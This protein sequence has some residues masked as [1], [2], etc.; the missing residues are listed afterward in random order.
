MSVPAATLADNAEKSFA[1]AWQGQRI[2]V[3]QALF[4]LVYNERSKLGITRRSKRDGLVVLTPFNGSYLQFDG[5]DSEEDITGRDV[6]QIVR[7]VSQQYRRG[8]KLEMGNYQKIEPLFVAR[9]EKG[10][11]LVV[12]GVTVDRDRVRFVFTEPPGGHDPG[13]LA[14][15]LTVKWP[16]PLSKSLS[17]RELIEKLVK[18]VIAVKPAR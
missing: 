6:N 2:V 1:R 11:E 12:S 3:K 4:A 7:T 14:T 9:Y 5:R 8:S 18:Q 10:A 17:E 16:V 15:S 13:D